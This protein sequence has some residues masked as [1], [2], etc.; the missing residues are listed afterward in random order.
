MSAINKRLPLIGAIIATAGFELQGLD[1]P[2]GVIGRIAV[3]V[4][5]VLAG[6]T[7]RRN[8]VTSEQAKRIER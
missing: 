5:L 1:D 7:M 6:G 2:W 4:G 8:N 3:A